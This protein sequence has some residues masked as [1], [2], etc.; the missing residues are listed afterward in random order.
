MKKS[1]SYIFT[2]DSNHDQ[3]LRHES[4]TRTI[5]KVMHAVAKKLPDK[6]NLTSHSFRSGYITQLWKGSKDIEFVK[7][8][9]AHIKI[10][11]TSLDVET[12]SNKER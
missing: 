8:A 7:Q 6:P 3:M 10:E 5:T 1:D 9:I 12:L 11:S 2:F 4:L